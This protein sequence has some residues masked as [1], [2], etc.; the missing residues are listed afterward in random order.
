[1][2]AFLFLISCTIN[3]LQW[4]IP[5]TKPSTHMKTTRKSYLLSVAIISMIALGSCSKNDA[6]RIHD[7]ATAQKVSVDRFSST[8]GHLQVRT[9]TNG[10]PAANA[11]V[12]F[13][14]GPFIT[15]G[16]GTQG[17]YVEYYNFDV[18][19]TMPAPIYVIFK[20]GESS[21]VMGQLNIIDVLP[22]EMGYNDFWQIVK[23]TVPS[24]YQAN[25]VASYN[26]ILARK[27][28]L[29]VTT[30]LVNCPVVPEG[31]T[32]VKRLNGESTALTQGWH[33]EKIVF[34]FNFGEKALSATAGMVPTAP[35]YVSFVINPNSSNP[36]SG[37]ASGFLAEPGSSMQTHNVVGA[38]PSDA[39]YSPLWVVNAYDNANFLSVRNLSTVLTA[40]SVGTGLALVNC[41]LVSIN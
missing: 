9:A 17:Q 34:Y 5:E 18:Q 22:G 4:L 27:Y 3:K 13:D 1:M 37:P 30:Q 14:Q 6:V 21:P 28:K 33:D 36:A 32:A 40:T 24:N 8:A 23:V 7:I 12:N 2:S 25:E 35:I 10:L 38:M 15:K 29:E 20:E 19:P 26:E 39:G 31:S 11:P 16:L 41:P